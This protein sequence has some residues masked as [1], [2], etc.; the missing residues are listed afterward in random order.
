ME[1]L[2]SETGY[3]QFESLSPKSEDAIHSDQL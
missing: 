2:S 1:G 3:G